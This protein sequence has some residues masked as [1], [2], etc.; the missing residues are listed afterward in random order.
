MERLSGTDSLF[1]AGETPTWHQHVAGL[2]IIDPT[3]VADFSFDTVIRSIGDRL[4]LIPKLTGARPRSTRPAPTS[5]SASPCAGGSATTSPRQHAASS[6]TVS[7]TSASADPAHGRIPTTTSPSPS[8]ATASRGHH[9]AT[10]DSCASAPK[11]ARPPPRADALT[12]S[13]ST[14]QRATSRPWS[15][16]TRRDRPWPTNTRPSDSSATA[17]ADR[18]RHLPSRAQLSDGLNA[19]RRRIAASSNGWAR[20]RAWWCP[21]APRCRASPPTSTSSAPHPISVSIS[22]K[23]PR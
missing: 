5:S 3:G 2:T 4:P 21:G 13:Q 7:D 18:R 9:S 22:P 20:K 10:P 16:V 19:S 17:E 23:N 11:P 8:S 1:L 14:C 6:R 15:V 12:A